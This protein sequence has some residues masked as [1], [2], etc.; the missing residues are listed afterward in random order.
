MKSNLHEISPID[1]CAN[2]RVADEHPL[3]RQRAKVVDV[4]GIERLVAYSYLERRQVAAAGEFVERGPVRRTD[5]ERR[6]QNGSGDY[7]QVQTRS[8]LSG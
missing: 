2:H 6:H 5:G 7:N 3:R 4:A 8:Q 1:A